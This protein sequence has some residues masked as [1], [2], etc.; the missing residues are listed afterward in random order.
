MK[1]KLAD[2]VGKNVTEVTPMHD[3]IQVVFD[4]GDCLTVFNRFVLS[5]DNQGIAVLDALQETRESLVL[6]FSDGRKL[7]VD[8]SPN[9]Y[10]GPEAIE[11]TTPDG[12][13]IIWRGD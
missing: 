8:L 6:E 1:H 3:Y 5:G 7:Q 2:L 11:W 9:G 13:F 10:L 12:A 4:T